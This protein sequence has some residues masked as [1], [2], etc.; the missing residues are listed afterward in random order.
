MF[1][2][3]KEV[4]D[5]CKALERNIETAVEMGRKEAPAGTTIPTYEQTKTFV[6]EECPALPKGK[7]I[8]FFHTIPACMLRTN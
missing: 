1:D 3:F 4:G 6:M 8:D 7:R 5:E 2:C